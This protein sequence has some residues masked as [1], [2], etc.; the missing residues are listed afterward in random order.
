[1][2]LK[3]D[4]LQDR[5][6][7][8]LQARPCIYQPGNFTGWAVKGLKASHSFRVTCDKNAREPAQQQRIALYKNSQESETLKEKGGGGGRRRKTTE[9][10][11]EK[12]M[13]REGEGEKE[14]Q[15]KQEKKKETQRGRGQEED[16]KMTGD[17][18]GDG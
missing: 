6:I 2:A 11:K 16:D 12:G 17:E 18:E 10:Q 14:G 4:V 3:V 8:C 5:K 9:K 13:G 1:M 15:L 7:Y